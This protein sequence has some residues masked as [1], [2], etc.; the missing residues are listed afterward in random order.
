MRGVDGTPLATL[1]MMHLIASAV[2]KG[3]L[4]VV[5]AYYGSS[6]ALK[7]ITW[8]NKVAY[9]KQHEY[10]IVDVYAVSPK[11]RAI[12]AAAHVKRTNQAIGP[13]ILTAAGHN[14][15]LL[16]AKLQIFEYLINKWMHKYDWIFWSDAD[17]VFL[18]FST[19]LTQYL[20]MHPM[21]MTRMVIAAGPPRNREWRGV[22]NTGNFFMKMDTWTQTLMRAAVRHAAAPCDPTIPYFNGWMEICVGMT[23]RM[24][25]RQVRGYTQSSNGDGYGTEIGFSREYPFNRTCCEWGD[26]G[27]LMQVI[28]TFG[29]MAQRHIEYVGF[30]EFN[31]HFPFYGEGDL[32]VHTPGVEAER[33]L[34]ILKTLLAT[35]HTPNGTFVSELPPALEPQNNADHQRGMDYNRLGGSAAGQTYATATH[36]IRE[37]EGRA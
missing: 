33:K 4:C 37:V 18:N 26:Q 30:R 5:S 32:V 21:S 15:P 19:P 22:I 7:N 27:V 2:A 34:R 1:V 31:S 14:D 35:L 17:S 13:K 8:P 11:V 25:R 23:P 24:I 28:Q 16:N 10:A 20:P 36:T 29:P 6:R 12:V 3:G 9:A